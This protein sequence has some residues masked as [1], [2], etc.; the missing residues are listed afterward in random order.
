MSVEKENLNLFARRFANC[1]FMGAI[2]NY[3]TVISPI[4]DGNDVHLIF[5]KNRL[6]Q[7]FVYAKLGEYIDSV[8]VKFPFVKALA[9]EK[10]GEIVYFRGHFNINERISI[11]DGR[12]YLV[13][14]NS[15]MDVNLYS[16]LDFT[17]IFTNFS[18]E[19]R[20]EERR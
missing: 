19:E 5:V 1:G 17:D 14:K 6:L 3:Q 18:K 9:I 15:S 7:S 4:L 13:Y 8:L 11:N 20:Y 2:K 16:F 10:E 12:L